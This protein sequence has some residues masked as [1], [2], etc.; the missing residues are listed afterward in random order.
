MARASLWSEVDELLEK[1]E[2]PVIRLTKGQQVIVKRP[3]GRPRTKP[4]GAHEH[5]N[6]RMKTPAGIAMRCRNHGC[7][8]KLKACAESLT[9]SDA[10]KMQL[11]RYCEITLAALR[12]EIPARDYPPDLRGQKNSFAKKRA[13]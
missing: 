9:C 4:H 12:G 11:E 8:K 7:S 13:A 2:R 3:P 10:C 1:G 6:W 5:Y